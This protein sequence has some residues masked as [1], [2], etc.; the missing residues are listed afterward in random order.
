MTT[1]CALT[2]TVNTARKTMRSRFVIPDGN[3]QRSHAQQ[4][5]LFGLKSAHTTREAQQ[6]VGEQNA[7]ADAY[8]EPPDLDE[9]DVFGHGGEID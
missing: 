7:H 8:I 3:R 6:S 1:I 9:Y 2:G 4:Q 5:Q